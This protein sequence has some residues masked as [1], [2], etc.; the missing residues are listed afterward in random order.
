MRSFAATALVAPFLLTAVL[1]APAAT[2]GTAD[3]KAIAIVNTHS[4]TTV[5]RVVVWQKWMPAGTHSI[6]VV[7]LAT[8]GHQR[9][10]ID[11]FLRNG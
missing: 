10:D 4:A 6:K 3:G 8:P 1:A 11:A 9:I 7:N 5:N 2:A